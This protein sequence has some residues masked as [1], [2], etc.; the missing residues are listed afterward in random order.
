[1]AP[2]KRLGTVSVSWPTHEA[3]A[4][5]ALAARVL[6]VIRIDAL[7]MGVEPVDMRAGVD[8]LL[9]RVV[10]MFGA[11]QAHHGYLASCPLTLELTPR[12]WTQPGEF[13]WR[14]TQS[15]P[16]SRR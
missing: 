4:C 2:R 13:T 1:M 8:T 14:N 3:V 6:A 7:W 10:Q 16:S 11:A 5:A 12:S 9:A 15:R